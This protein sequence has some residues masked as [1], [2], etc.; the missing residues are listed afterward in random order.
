MIDRDD[1]TGCGKGPGR[2]SGE[3]VGGLEMAAA[4]AEGVASTCMTVSVSTVDAELSGITMVPS[5]RLLKIRLTAIMPAAPVSA[6][7]SA[8]T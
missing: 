2:A 8:P 5:E 6:L 1:S 7:R 4:G 3:G